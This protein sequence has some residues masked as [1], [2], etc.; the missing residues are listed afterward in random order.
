LLL[1]RAFN[2]AQPQYTFG[3][4]RDLDYVRPVHKVDTLVFA[5]ST[6]HPHDSGGPCPQDHNHMERTLNYKAR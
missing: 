1:S 3:C 5:D 2:G 6:E 4:T